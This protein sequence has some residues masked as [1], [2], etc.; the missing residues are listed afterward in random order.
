MLNKEE[1]KEQIVLTVTREKTCK[2]TEINKYLSIITINVNVLNSPIRKHRLLKN[3]IQMVFVNI[4]KSR[5]VI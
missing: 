5:N 2:T 4:C 3:K 1:R